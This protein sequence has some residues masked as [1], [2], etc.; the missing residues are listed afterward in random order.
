MKPQSP[1]VQQN[2]VSWDTHTLFFNYK[3]IYI[4]GLFLLLL[5]TQYIIGVDRFFLITA[6][7][8]TYFYYWI[9]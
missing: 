6:K 1:I 3:R 5:S 9:P 7:S 4:R 8:D 2:L